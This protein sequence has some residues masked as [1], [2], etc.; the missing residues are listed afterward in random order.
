M[1]HKLLIRIEDAA[2]NAWP[3]RRQMILDGWLLRFAE[4]YTKRSNSV[5]VRFDSRLPLAE[6]IRICEL[7]HA[8]AGLPVVFRL[9]DPFT[10]QVV[11]QAL[12]QAG[13]QVFDPTYVLGQ[14]IA[15]RVAVPEGVQ[16]REM[17][18]EAWIAS[19]A[20]L[21]GTSVDDWDV[22]REILDLILPE[23]VLL[24]LFVEGQPVACGM[25]VVEGDLLGYFSVYVG[26]DFRRR[27][28]GQMTMWALRNWG[29]DRGAHYG[30]LQVDG[31]NQPALNMYQKM[32]FETCY[33]YVYSKKKGNGE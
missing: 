10:S 27:G 22:H 18:P 26:K 12:D 32:G 16:M 5:N 13:Y 29:L 4:G 24:G 30:Y 6:K 23:K 31:D 21:T 15:E 8:R 7:A 17:R 2:L 9:P 1:D 28:Y 33:R 3:A 19:R 14:S 20:D 25:G 11:I